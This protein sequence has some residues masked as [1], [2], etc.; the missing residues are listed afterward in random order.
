[1]AKR[2]EERKVPC[3]LTLANVAL[4]ALRHVGVRPRRSQLELSA[5]L[6]EAAAPSIGLISPLLD[7]LQLN[8]RSAL[9]VP[10]VVAARRL[11]RVEL[12]DA[13]PQKAGG[14]G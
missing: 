7:A 8:I 3:P 4:H 13:A 10:V 1:M 11:D 9:T 14:R 2:A 5:R 6:A 12:G